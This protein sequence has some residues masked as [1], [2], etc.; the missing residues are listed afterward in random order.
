MISYGMFYVSIVK[1]NFFNYFLKLIE[2]C[3]VLKFKIYCFNEVK[4]C[5]NF[6]RNVVFI[7][8]IIK[9]FFFVSVEVRGGLG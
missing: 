8:L 9:S 7:L 2:Y 6:I 5:K 3:L 4:I 1:N